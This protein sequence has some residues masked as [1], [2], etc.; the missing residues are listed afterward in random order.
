[1][2]EKRRSGKG[3]APRA[4]VFLDIDAWLDSTLYDAGFKL[5]EF[6]ENTTIFFRRFRVFGL[7]RALVEVFS[8]AVTLAAA[9]AVVMLALAMPAFEET[10][11]DWLAQD[12]YAVTFLTATATRSVSAA[13]AS[14]IPCRSTNYPTI[15]SRPSSPRRIAGSSSTSASMSSASS[16]P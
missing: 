15:S 10:K 7:K 4:T 12:D 6:W 8:E 9:G 5:A 14:A 13:S 11:G 2:D 1:M 3:K 16:A